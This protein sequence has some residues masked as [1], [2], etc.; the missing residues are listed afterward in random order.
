MNKIKFGLIEKKKNRNNNRNSIN[1]IN[2]F[3]N[4]NNL[5]NLKSFNK[6]NNIN[7]FNNIKLKTPNN[8]LNIIEV[9][10]DNRN[11][12]HKE[13][14]EL[15]SLISKIKENRINNQSERSNKT[16]E[17]N[18]IF[19]KLKINGSDISIENNLTNGYP[20]NSIYNN[21]GNY[22]SYYNKKVKDDYKNKTAFGY[23]FYVKN[24]KSLK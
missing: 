8:K 6:V 3:N 17:K 14:D 20:S 2:N 1:N 5:N 15:K 4:I 7:Y 11:T 19:R 22:Y 23:L 21:L 13:K 10:F 12:I 18:K 24:N 16:I 9:N